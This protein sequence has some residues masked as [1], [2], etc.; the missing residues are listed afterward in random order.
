M[1]KIKVGT[2]DYWIGRCGTRE[3]LR[4]LIR[5]ADG[6][7]MNGVAGYSSRSLE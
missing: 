1:R 5:G 4:V 7:V 2:K 6:D 3:I